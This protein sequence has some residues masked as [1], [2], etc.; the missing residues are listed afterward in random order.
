[1]YDNIDY[2][3]NADIM[4]LVDKVDQF[5][6]E[7]VR[8]YPLRASQ[9]QLLMA[10]QFGHYS[11]GKALYRWKVSGSDPSDVFYFPSHLVP[12]LWLLEF[13]HEIYGRFGLQIKLANEVAG[14]NQVKKHAPINPFSRVDTSQNIE[15]TVGFINLMEKLMG[16]S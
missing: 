15:E 5:I 8:I 4:E 13:R 7:C 14:T 1:M 6:Q 16:R 2:G 3:F 12:C 11:Y 10:A 9:P